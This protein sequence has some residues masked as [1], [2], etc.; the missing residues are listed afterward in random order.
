MS[1]YAIVEDIE[2]RLMKKW[3]GVKMFPRK[4]ILKKITHILRIFQVVAPFF[5]DT[6]P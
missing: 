5:R 4:I 3:Q 2:V 1:L 6:F